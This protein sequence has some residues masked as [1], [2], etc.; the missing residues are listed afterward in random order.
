MIFILLLFSS[1]LTQISQRLSKTKSIQCNFNET[2]MMQNDTLTFSGSVY[3]IRDKARIDVFEPEIETMLFEGD[4]VFIWRE[5]TEQIY[6]KKA[7]IIFQK[8]LFNPSSHYRIDSTD[9]DWIHL[10]PIKKNLSH[11]ISLT[12][13]E[14]FLPQKL[15]F[16]QKGGVGIFSFKSYKL[17]K[18]YA[19]DFFSLEHVLKE[20]NGNE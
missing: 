17:N 4:S 9:S 19:E 12:L 7:P 3:A 16:T 11:P 20:R 14:N 2:L 1:V 13:N 15:K 6:R 8:V 5:K 10:S 18:K